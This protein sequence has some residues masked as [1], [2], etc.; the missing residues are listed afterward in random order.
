MHSHNQF[1]SNAAQASAPSNPMVAIPIAQTA[2]P[3][4]GNL[5]IELNT[6]CASQKINQFLP[7]L[8]AL[9][10]EEVSDIGELELEDLLEI[11]VPKLHARRAW[12]S[13]KIYRK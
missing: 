6:W 13:A 3:Q 8:Q 12:R 2:T 4:D 11:G 10:V 5:I 7:Q 9:G 1:L